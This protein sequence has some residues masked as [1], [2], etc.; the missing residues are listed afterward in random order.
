MAASR[1]FRTFSV[2]KIFDCRFFPLTNILSKCHI[3]ENTTFTPSRL[4][5]SCTQSRC[6]AINRW[7]SQSTLPLAVPQRLLFRHATIVLGK[8]DQSKDFHTSCSRLGLEEF[9]DDPKTYGEPDVKSGRPW[10]ADELRLKDNATLHK[11]WYV[12]LKESNMLLTMEAEAERQD[13]RMPGSDRHSKVKRSMRNLQQVM[14]ERNEVLTELR[15]G[16]PEEHP[17]KMVYTPFGYL[18]YIKPK[19][20]YVPMYANKTYHRKR[21]RYKP[22]VKK[23]LNLWMEKE[24]D[25]RRKEK[26]QRKNQ[27]KK[28]KE[29]YPDAD[30]WQN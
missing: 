3:S 26:R 19:E 7:S 11:L 24:N 6:T 28:L 5:C 29:R 9:F 21:Y 2:A 10:S 14:Q 30:V 12:L 13:K 15:T 16:G 20:H 4:Q 22:F 25:K 8:T 17:A 27:I 1:A 18:R 23:Y